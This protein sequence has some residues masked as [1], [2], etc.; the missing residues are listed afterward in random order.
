MLSEYERTQEAF[1]ANRERLKVNGWLARQR[2]AKKQRES[3]KSDRR[4][5]V[6]SQ[7]FFKPVWLKFLVVL[8]PDAHLPAR[9]DHRG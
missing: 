7:Q 8:V 4:L 1:H 6:K 3:S 5:A 2:R 9:L